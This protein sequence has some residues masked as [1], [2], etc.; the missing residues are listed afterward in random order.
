MNPVNLTNSG[1]GSFVKVLFQDSAGYL[2]EKSSTNGASIWNVNDSG[3]R[4]MQV[5]NGTPIAAAASPQEANNN[6]PIR[7][8]FVNT[9]GFLADV[10]QDIYGGSW[11]NG[12][13]VDRRFRPY[14]AK[15][16]GVTHRS[17]SVSWCDGE[18]L[19]LFVEAADLTI[20]AFQL[21]TTETSSSWSLIPGNYGNIKDISSSDNFASVCGFDGLGV[22]PVF[23]NYY[24]GNNPTGSIYTWW[25]NS[26][27]TLYS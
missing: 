16:Q 5:L 25:N 19:T 18:S 12:S 26:T 11:T 7:V 23:V 8:F 17:L 14:A 3:N 6:L 9:D 15:V 21:T 24:G 1:Y 27:Y 4:I 10:Y 22:P 13:L 2:S 20:N